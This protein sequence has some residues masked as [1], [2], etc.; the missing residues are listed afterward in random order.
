MV[1][2]L[3][4]KLLR[5]FRCRVDERSILARRISF[6]GGSYRRISPA[7]HPRRSHQMRA[8]IRPI[9]KRQTNRTLPAPCFHSVGVSR[10]WARIRPAIDPVTAVPRP[11]GR[12]LPLLGP[13]LTARP[14]AAV[15][16]QGVEGAA[17]DV[18]AH[19]RQV[20][21]APAADEHDAV[22]L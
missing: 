4:R 22:L 5:L 1:W 14:L 9:M 8:T 16:T 12:L 10:A 11:R 7:D 15:D 18:V 2:C 17:D 6:W 21:H 20:A 13:V 19:A 3:L